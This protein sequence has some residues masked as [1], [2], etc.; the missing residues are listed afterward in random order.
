MEF[1]VEDEILIFGVKAA[2]S[3]SPATDAETYSRVAIDMEEF[4]KDPDWSSLA[5]FNAPDFCRAQS[6]IE[7][8]LGRT[9]SC[10]SCP[11]YQPYSSGDRRVCVISRRDKIDR[12]KEAYE[13]HSGE[14]CLGI[15]SF[16]AY[17]EALLEERDG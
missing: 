2:T 12:R 1:E 11:M 3:S 16:K 4:L 8:K 5:L 7:S 10:A 17:W 6:I 13:Q 14:V 9:V 15:Y